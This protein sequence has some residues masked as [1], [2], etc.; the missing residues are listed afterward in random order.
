[1]NAELSKTIVHLIHQGFES[2]INSFKELTSHAPHF[3]KSRDWNASQ[4][5][6]RRRLLLYKDQVYA[7]RLILEGILKDQ[8]GNI[9]LWKEIKSDYN[10][11]ITERKDKELAETFFNSVI[12]KTFPG[13][14]IS[15]ELM[16]VREGYDTC[17]IH[18]QEHL[19]Y[20][21]PSQWGLQKIIR[22]IVAD[23]DFG[24]PYMEKEKDIQYLVKA[25]REVILTRFQATSETTTQVLKSVFYRNKAAYLIGRTRIGGK[26]MPFI[27]PYM[28]GPKGIY[29]DTLIFD[30]NI[31]SGLFSFS[32]SYFM[33][34][35][36]IPSQII[37]FL[38]SVISQKLIHELYN[39]I[40]F[41]K[42][43]KTEFYRDFLN[44]LERTSDPF[45][46]AEGIKG[47]VMTVF[48][49]PS[50][51]IVFKMIKDHFEPPKSM[52]RLEVRQKYKLV[53]L[54]DRVGRMA[55]THEFEF[56]RLPLDRIHPELVTELKNTCNSLL[57]FTQDEL[58]IKHLYTERRMVPLNIYLDS[59][60]LEE[61][62]HVVEEYGNAILQL[63]QA[64]IFP[65]DM[66]VKNFGVTRQK[67]VIFYDYDEIEF[68][69]DMNFRWKPKAENYEQIY[70]S[71][72][73]YDI[74]KNDVF[75]EDFRRFMIGRA[76]VKPHFLAFHEKLFNP[77]HWNQIQEKIRTGELLHAFP[78]P[79]SMR[80][81]PE[82]EV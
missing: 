20:N 57:E 27:I 66:M 63:A 44:H 46:Q 39:A 37:A 9:M 31:M 5:N 21:Y 61:A 13:L 38:N 77:D 11:E 76:D 51:N 17:D 14:A 2:Y 71:A 72:P 59:C 8:V 40:G 15:D 33:V 48:T 75:P 49:L 79:K 54:H 41:N 4:Q 81:R 80:F 16:F 73:W 10:W 22:K 55:D 52:T 70:A 50:Y 23:F 3:F 28:N 65:G 74:A 36:E 53:S 64:N 45:I 18:P 42:H 78:Y 1:M 60:T 56:F 43:G 24:V 12:R 67:R 82:E 26:W 35:A 62:K 29:V 34:E 32:R 47:M 19:F 30:P 6:H 58:I 68:L 69:T 25:V 7:T